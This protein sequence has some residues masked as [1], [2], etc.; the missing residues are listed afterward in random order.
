MKV[1]GAP[2]EKFILD[3]AKVGDK[4]EYWQKYREKEEESL[5]KLKNYIILHD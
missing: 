3:S 5:T 2:K 4:K 1:H